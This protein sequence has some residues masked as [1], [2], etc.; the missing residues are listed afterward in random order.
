[1][2]HA[3]R[4]VKHDSWVSSWFISNGI[5]TSIHDLISRI[6]QFDCDGDQLNV[7]ANKTI[8][9]VAKRNIEEHHIVPL[10]YDANE[11]PPELINRETLFR[12]LVRA[13]D[14]S[15]IGQISNN[16]CKLWNSDEPDYEAAKL[17]CYFN[18]QVNRIAPSRSDA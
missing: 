3:V 4:K 5:Y 15:G 6:L 17:L 13:H 9:A 16:L 8:I 2:E 10:F 18:N 7:V 11:V 12:G 1:M 14:S